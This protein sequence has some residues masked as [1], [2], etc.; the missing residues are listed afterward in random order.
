MDFPLDPVHVSSNPTSCS[1]IEW[2][3]S[4]LPRCVLRASDLCDLLVKDRAWV[5]ATALVL[6]EA[7]TQGPQP[8]TV[9][10]VKICR[11]PPL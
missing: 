10:T 9:D 8:Q 5:H 4:R 11:Q 1:I 6:T 3:L 7:Y 2:Q